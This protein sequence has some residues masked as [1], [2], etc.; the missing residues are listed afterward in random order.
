MG[1]PRQSKKQPTARETSGEGAA[2]RRRTEGAESAEER[3][4][5]S[6]GTEPNDPRLIER[7]RDAHNPD[8]L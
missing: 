3:A 1:E 2:R 6:R 5:P 7:R 4:D 8:G